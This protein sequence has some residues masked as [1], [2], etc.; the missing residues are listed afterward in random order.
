MRR[1]GLALLAAAGT[2]LLPGCTSFTD[3]VRAADSA[4]APADQPVDDGACP[5]ERA[6]PDPDRP[7]V[8]LDFR[9]ADDGAA[10]TGTETVVFTP[11]RDVREM[12]FRLVP[13]GPDSAPAGNRLVVDAV[14]GDDVAGGTYDAAGAASPGGLYVVELEDELP[15]GESTEVELDFTLSLGSGTFDR[16]GHDDGLSWWASGAPLLAWEP[17]V[18]W[19]RDPF[20]PLS[21]ET[22]SSPVADTRVSVSAPEELTVVMTGTPAEP[23]EPRGG[24]RTW[25][26]R[27]PVARDVAVAA[28][29]FAIAE[30]ETPGGVLVRA[31]ALPGGDLEPGQLLDE[32]MRSIAALE[33][34]LGPFPYETETVALLP[35]YGGG[36]EYPGFIFEATPSPAVLAHELAHM[37]F[38][39]MVGNSQ[40]RDPWLDEAFASWAE[41]VVDGK[42]DLV[43]ESAI[44]LRGPV[45]GS[46]ADYSNTGAY[47]RLVYDK[48]GAALLAAREAAGPEA[49]DDAVRCYVDANAWSI[50]TPEDLGAALADLPAAVDVLVKAEALEEDDVPR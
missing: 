28:G 8:A 25:T 12:V 48:G 39:G 26:S 35:N 9:L 30:R 23:S 38:Y 16:F 3:T 6:A 41:A 40:F 34:F 17:G 14:R 50:A 20:V 2:L 49:F 32:T 13:N 5:D 18:G 10:V 1:R 15:A 22:A 21:G 36:I 24:R 37:W 42:D 27:E 46:M 45:G 43:D 19:A 47:F 31:A 4:A 29:P 44:D 11:D 7:E 33:E